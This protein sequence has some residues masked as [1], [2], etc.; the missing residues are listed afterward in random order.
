MLWQVLSNKYG[1]DLELASHR[2]SKGK[3]SV[4]MG[5]EAGGKKTSKVLVYPNGSAEPIVFEGRLKLYCALEIH[6]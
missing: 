4:S 5:F 3:T 6:E 2:D 1:F